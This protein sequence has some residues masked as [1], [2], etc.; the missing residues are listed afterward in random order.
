MKKMLCALYV[1]VMLSVITQE[2]HAGKAGA[3][4]GGF[5]GGTIVG[6]ALAAPRPRE[7]VVIQQAVPVEPSTTV[8]RLRRENQDLRE[9]NNYLQT[10]NRSLARENTK[11]SQKAE[12]TELELESLNEEISLLQKEIKRLEQENKLLKKN[13]S[14]K[15]KEEPI[16]KKA[17]NS[18]EKQ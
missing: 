3:A 8:S 4:I 13:T 12:L 7:T 18:P 2:A 16:D 15:T 10:E 9:D 1:F 5:L 14:E 6:S 11:L 17:N